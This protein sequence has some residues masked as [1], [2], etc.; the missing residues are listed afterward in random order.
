MQDYISE[1]I[2]TTWT[3]EG[4]TDGKHTLFIRVRALII[5]CRKGNFMFITL[6]SMKLYLLSYGGLLQCYSGFSARITQNSAIYETSRNIN[7]RCLHITKIRVDET[8]RDMLQSIFI[9]GKA[10]NRII[11]IIM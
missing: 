8:L 5:L 1:I 3:P 10:H 7:V 2:I 6:Y 4:T 9:I 11:L